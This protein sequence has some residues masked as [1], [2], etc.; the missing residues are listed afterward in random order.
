VK[1]LGSIYVSFFLKLV[2]TEKYQWVNK[3]LKANNFSVKTDTSN[4]KHLEAM[5]I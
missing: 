5:K 1:T 2:I 3:A 4:N